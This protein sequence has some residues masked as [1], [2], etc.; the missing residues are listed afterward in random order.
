MASALPQ[1]GRHV[2]A[3]LAMIN[4]VRMSFPHSFQHHYAVSDT[5]TRAAL[6]S[7]LVAPLNGQS[8]ILALQSREGSGRETLTLDRRM[9]TLPFVC[10][11]SLPNAQLLNVAGR[12]C[13]GD[14]C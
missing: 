10:S 12:C 7:G 4:W 14:L 9:A 13:E 1:R 11:R 8:V 6:T 5:D 3:L 2:A